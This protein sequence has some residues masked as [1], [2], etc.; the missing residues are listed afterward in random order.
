LAISRKREFLADASGALLTRDPEGLAM[1]L[2]KIAKLEKYTLNV[3]SAIS[4][5]LFAPLSTKNKF[6]NWLINL[7]STHPP[8]EE[9]IKALRSMV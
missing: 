5:L 3:S 1:A 9:R 6:K 4:P 8:I 7:F 2:E